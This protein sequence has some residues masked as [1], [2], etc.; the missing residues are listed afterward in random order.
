MAIR[1]RSLVVAALLGLPA[2]MVIGCGQEAQEAVQAQA[3]ARP[4]QL[5]VQADVCADASD[6]LCTP[7][8]AHGKHGGYACSVCHKVAGRLAFDKAGPAY[9]TGL[10]APSFDA[11]A[12]TCSNVA[13]H[14]VKPGTFSYYFPDG[15]GDPQLYTVNYGGG[16]PPTSPAWTSTGAGCAACHGNPPKYGSDGSN[17]WHS[18]FH[19]N[20]GP[21]GAANQC[22]F[23]HPDAY[24][25]NN[26]I[27][28]TIT[29]ASLHGN[30]V[31]N[32]Q[33]SF[34]SSCFGCH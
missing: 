10:P 17:V 11:T 28:T 29:N 2:L 30:G 20:Q 34:K 4:K 13:C 14:S 19:A 6:P 3:S 31:V 27:G 8:G 23:C 21:T 18:G 5:L 9:G 26:G 25:P 32:V 16:A 22:Q 15:A 1:N 7:T 33:A 12:K 24:S